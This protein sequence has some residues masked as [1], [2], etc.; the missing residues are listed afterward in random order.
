MIKTSDYGNF[1]W[2]YEQALRTIGILVE[3]LGGQVEFDIDELLDVKTVIT[4]ITAD[5]GKVRMVTQ[6]K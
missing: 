4:T 5:S 1:N 6:T 2:K 3:R